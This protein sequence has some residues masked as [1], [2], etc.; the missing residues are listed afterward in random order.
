MLK[1]NAPLDLA[2]GATV[3]LQIVGEGAHIVS[4]PGVCGG[5]PRLAGHRITVQNVAIWHERLGR[6]A[7]EIA[8][9]SNLSL[10]EV[11]AALAYYFDHRDEI[12]KS[13]R[14]GL[15]FADEMRKKHPSLVKQKLFGNRQESCSF[16]VLIRS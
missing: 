13:I 14:E 12:E 4:T 6:S 5:K 7:D 3:E 1:I 16:G 10:A 9:D 15:A 8:N 11:H 2:E